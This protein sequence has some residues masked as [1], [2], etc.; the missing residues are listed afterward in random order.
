[1]IIGLTGPTG[2][3]KS[4][5]AKASLE[6][7][8]AVIDC[9][10]EA[11]LATEKG[12]EGLRLLC[13]EFGDE[14]LL[15]DGELNRKKLAALAFA[16]ESDTK[17]L[18][19]TLLPIIIKQIEQRIATLKADGFDD[20]LLDAPTL[21]ES[22]ADKFCDCV[23]AVLS[24]REIRKNRILSRDNLTEADAEIRLNASKPDSFYKDRT[25]HIL[26]NNGQKQKFLNDCNEWLSKLAE[27]I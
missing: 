8:F 15:P 14:I 2:S 3:G 23:V 20:I 27:K 19:Q 25:G 10:K 21:Y 26:Y 5:F 22:G 17:R 6:K 4:T 1:M 18:N 12:S 16:T 13:L 11:R 9:D 24:D 7:G